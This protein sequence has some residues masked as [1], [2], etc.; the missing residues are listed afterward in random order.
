MNPID[1]KNLPCFLHDFC[2]PDIFYAPQSLLYVDFDVFSRYICFF[3]ISGRKIDW[4]W[5]CTIVL[6]D[7]YSRL[8]FHQCFIEISVWYTTSKVKIRRELHRGCIFF[9]RPTNTHIFTACTFLAR[10]LGAAAFV[11]EKKSSPTIPREGRLTGWCIVA[12]HISLTHSPGLWRTLQHTKSDTTS[13]LLLP[14]PSAPFTL[15]QP[16]PQLLPLLILL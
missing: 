9:H 4:W 12:A 10:S 16:S 5:F 1:Q 8:M 15:R 7:V 14:P 13:P 11:C 6:Y 3:F 2:S